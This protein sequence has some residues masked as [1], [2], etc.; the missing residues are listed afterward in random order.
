M[1][2][3]FIINAWAYKFTEIHYN[4]NKL[5]VSKTFGKHLTLGKQVEQSWG[6]L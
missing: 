4:K 5:P 6:G 3:A 1:T 2:T